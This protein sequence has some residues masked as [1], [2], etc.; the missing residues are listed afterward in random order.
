MILKLSTGE[1][2]ESASG[3]EVDDKGDNEV[4]EES[5]GSSDSGED[6]NEFDENVSSAESSSGNETTGRCSICLQRFIDQEVGV[7]EECDHRFCLVCI[8]EWAKVINLKYNY[9]MMY[10]EVTYLTKYYI[11]N[12]P[13]RH[14]QLTENL[15]MQ[16]S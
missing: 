14:V 3:E 15:S 12:R 16:C 8:K 11:I 5:G 4:N 1:V 13:L 6:D 9:E 10:I 7:P 2:E